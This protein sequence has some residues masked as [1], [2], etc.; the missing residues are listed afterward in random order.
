MIVVFEGPRSLVNPARDEC[1]H[2]SEGKD[3]V[4]NHPFSPDAVEAFEAGGLEPSGRLIL[5]TDEDAHE[6][7]ADQGFPSG[8][9][10]LERAWGLQYDSDDPDS[11]QRFN[12][13]FED[14]LAEALKEGRAVDWRNPPP[15]FPAPPVP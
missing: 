2:S 10:F 7:L 8:G 14:F 1:I 6:F 4:S 12:Q 13:R 15:G 3:Y 9:S 5:L 11:L